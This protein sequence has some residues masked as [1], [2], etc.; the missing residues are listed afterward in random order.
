MIKVRN[1]DLI[2]AI[3][4]KIKKL[5]KELDLSQEKLSYLADVPISQIGRIERG[6]IN[7]TISSLYVISIALEIEL[8]NLVDVE[9]DS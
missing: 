9:I 4:L 5:R 2:K 8:P 3:G 1:E 6:E 7:P